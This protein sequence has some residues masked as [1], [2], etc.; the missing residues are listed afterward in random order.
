MAR[1]NVSKDPSGRIIVSFPYGALLVA[2]VKAIK[3]FR[4]HPTEK[5]WSFQSLHPFQSEKHRK[6]KKSVGQFKSE[7]R[8]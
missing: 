3:G 1:I 8:R 7:S 6:D 4:W 2:K 5:H